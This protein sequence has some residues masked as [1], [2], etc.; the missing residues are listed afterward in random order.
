MIR[1]T[2]T[3]IKNRPQLKNSN[4][5]K[6]T[7][8]SYRV[9]FGDMITDGGP[10]FINIKE[11]LSSKPSVFKQKMVEAIKDG[12]FPKNLAYKISKNS[13]NQKDK[14]LKTILLIEAIE[15]NPRYF[16]DAKEIATETLDAAN[17][18]KNKP[19]QKKLQRK[20]KE[21]DFVYKQVP[22]GNIDFYLS[23]IYGKKIMK[24]LYKV[25]F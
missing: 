3:E 6:D 14:V 13:P 23:K 24:I 7:T 22:S 17:E 5:K 12:H 25:L 11:L 18:I 9:A 8:T 21:L 4:N 16:Q 20:I 2:S 15:K 19:L 10:G 1:I